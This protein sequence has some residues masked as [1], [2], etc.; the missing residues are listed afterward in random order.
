MNR[1]LQ[2]LASA[3][4]VVSNFKVYCM[5]SFFFKKYDEILIKF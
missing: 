1:I 2:E 4:W 3:T 5:T